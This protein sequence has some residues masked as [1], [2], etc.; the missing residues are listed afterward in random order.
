MARIQRGRS[1]RVAA[2]KPQAQPKPEKQIGGPLV[3]ES[4]LNKPTTAA[5]PVASFNGQQTHTAGHHHGRMMALADAISH[6]VVSLHNPETAP[7]DP[8]KKSNYR[9]DTFTGNATESA[10][11]KQAHA[12]LEVAYAS[13]ARHHLHHSAGNHE[14]AAAYLDQA[15]KKLKSAMSR[16]SSS[17]QGSVTSPNIRG[18]QDTFRTTDVHKTI[19][20]NVNNYKT[21]HKIGEIAAPTDIKA[22][23]TEAEEIPQSSGAPAVLQSKVS[24]GRDITLSG[25][26]KTPGVIPN[27]P[28]TG[29][30]PAERKLAERGIGEIKKPVQPT[31]ERSQPRQISDE[32][33][34]YHINKVYHAAATGKATPWASMAHLKDAEIDALHE[35]IKTAGP[36]GVQK[37]VNKAKNVIGNYEK[38]QAKANK[39][40]TT[41]YTPRKV[42][43]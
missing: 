39:G 10:S 1:A 12:D 31:V 3:S 21:V 18:V 4:T 17:L 33:R 16:V 42:M 38:K 2:P 14:A 27:R 36:E 41:N 19:D 40:M 43:K 30:T 8:S 34:E 5:E 15:G 23:R 29:P 24:L 20:Q 9:H 28:S 11:R 35:H 37:M 13:L 22:E 25:S 6:S 32:E 26:G 7:V